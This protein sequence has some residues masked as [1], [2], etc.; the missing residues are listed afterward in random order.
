[1]KAWT[2]WLCFD[3]GV[4]SPPK[5][6]QDPRVQ[7]RDSFPAVP[8]SSVYHI[9]QPYNTA[10]ILQVPET[11]Q[12]L[13]AFCL[14]YRALNHTAFLGPFQRL[15]QAAFFRRSL[16]ERKGNSWMQFCT[17]L[18][19]CLTVRPQHRKSLQTTLLSL[20]W[21]CFWEVSRQACVSPR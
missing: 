16:Q 7:R 13:G 9:T 20:C 19:S 5:P 15:F 10:R 17:F 2:K 3:R 1:M 8:C 11:A 14:T 21:Q 18:C 4:C 6:S 12:H